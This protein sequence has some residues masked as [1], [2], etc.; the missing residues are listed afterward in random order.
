MCD[1]VIDAFICC[2]E[3]AGSSLSEQGLSP[4]LLRKGKITLK[5]EITIH[6]FSSLGF[7]VRVK[8]FKEFIITMSFE[9]TF[10]VK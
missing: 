9:V 1:P 2:S 6:T 4:D 5:S 8:I 3:S 10:D 7:V